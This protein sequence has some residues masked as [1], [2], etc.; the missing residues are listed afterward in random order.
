M[1]VT[2]RLQLH[3]ALLRNERRWKVDTPLDLCSKMSGTMGSVK[4]ETLRSAKPEAIS[5]WFLF[6]LVVFH[7]VNDMTAPY[8]GQCTM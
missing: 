8:P 7:G 1:R 3:S 4:L 5:M 2:C 6:C